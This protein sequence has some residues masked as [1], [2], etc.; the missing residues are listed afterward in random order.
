MATEEGGRGLVVVRGDSAVL[1]E[2]GKEVLDHRG[3]RPLLPRHCAG[4]LARWW[5]RSWR[6]RCPRPAPGSRRRAPTR[7]SCSSASGAGALPG[8]PRSAQADRATG[9]QH[10]SG[11]A[12][13]PRT[14]S[15][16]GLSRLSGLRVQAAVP[17]CAPIDRPSVHIFLSSTLSAV[18]CCGRTTTAPHPGWP[19]RSGGTPTPNSS[20]ACRRPC[21]PCAPGSAASWP[22]SPRTKQ[23]LRPARAG[24]RMH[25]QRQ[26]PHPVRVRRQGQHRHHPQ[27][28]PGGGHAQHAGQSYDGHTLAETLEQVEILADCKPKTA[29]VDKGY[30]GIQLEGGAS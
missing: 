5:S 6:T 23:A 28:R 24:S 11:T 12:P 29:I 19:H 3:L 27:G 30:R 10:G 13:H 21:A 1:L 14:T 8:S 18:P 9:C 15:C 2:P 17:G 22:R 7:R 16:P 4:G 25:L 20:G 26:G